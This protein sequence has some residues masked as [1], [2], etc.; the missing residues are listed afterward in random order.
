MSNKEETTNDNPLRPSIDV[1]IHYKTGENI[2]LRLLDVQG[3][4]SG[5]GPDTD[6]QE[7]LW[8]SGR[9]VLRRPLQDLRELFPKVEDAGDIEF[10]DEDSS[11][12]TGE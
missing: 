8:Q 11:P 3:V 9:L 10:R 2:T 4:G 12:C 1:V 5:S 7:A 6:R